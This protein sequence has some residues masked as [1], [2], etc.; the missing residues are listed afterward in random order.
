MTVSAFVND[1]VLLLSCKVG[2]LFSLNISQPVLHLL[3]RPSLS[4]RSTSLILKCAIQMS[5][6]QGSG[7]R[8]RREGNADAGPLFTSAVTLW[9]QYSLALI[10]P[11]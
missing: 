8:A 9:Q 11:R 10:G 4:G 7:G 3:A 6:L 1:A 2:P 5:F